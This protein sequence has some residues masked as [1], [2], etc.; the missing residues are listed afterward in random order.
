MRSGT[1]TR[2]GNMAQNQGGT[3]SEKKVRARDIDAA[4]ERRGRMRERSTS[5]HVRRREEDVERRQRGGQSGIGDNNGGRNPKGM[6]GLGLGFGVIP[7]RDGGNKL[8]ELTEAVM[9]SR[10]DGLP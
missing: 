5:T 6:H 4:M 9:D 7:N 2:D 1:P 10:I 8:E 3:T